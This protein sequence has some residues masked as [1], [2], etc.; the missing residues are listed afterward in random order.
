MSQ[1]SLYEYIRNSQR[2]LNRSVHLTPVRK[3][4][5][6]SLFTSEYLYK[7][8]VSP[9][10]CLP[11]DFD[12]LSGDS[13]FKDDFSTSTHG[14]GQKSNEQKVRDLKPALGKRTLSSP[15]LHGQRTLSSPSLHGQRLLSSPSRHRSPIMSP[16]RK[17][18]KAKVETPKQAPPPSPFSQTKLAKLLMKHGLSIDMSDDSNKNTDKTPTR[19]SDEDMKKSPK[20]NRA[21]PMLS[22]D[23]SRKTLS[24]PIRL[25][26]SQSA[27]H[28]PTTSSSS[29]MTPRTPKTPSKVLHVKS[30]SHMEQ[31]SRKM[32]S[33]RRPNSLSVNTALKRQREQRT[34][35]S[36]DECGTIIPGSYLSPKHISPTQ[37]RKNS[38]NQVAVACLPQAPLSP[39]G[40]EAHDFPRGRVLV[41]RES[42]SSQNSLLD[43]F[44]LPRSS[45]GDC[46][47][48][49]L[50]SDSRKSNHSC[51]ESWIDDRDSK[52]KIMDAKVACT[53]E[54]AFLNYW[55]KETKQEEGKARTEESKPVDE[56]EK[57]WG[58]IDD[59]YES[60]GIKLED[61]HQ[62]AIAGTDDAEQDMIEIESQ[63]PTEC[64]EDRDAEIEDEAET[65]Y[66]SDGEEC[67]TETET[68]NNSEDC[69]I[70]TL[71]SKEQGLQRLEEG[72]QEDKKDGS[73]VQLDV[74]GIEITPRQQMLKKMKDL[75]QSFSNV[76]GRMN[77]AAER[78]KAFEDGDD[79]METDY[80]SDG[81]LTVSSKA[82]RSKAKKSK[83][84][85][86]KSRK[87]SRDKSSKGKSAV[88]RS[89]KNKSSRDKLSKDS[90]PKEKSKS[91][92]A[93]KGQ[94]EKVLLQEVKGFF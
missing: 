73:S 24:A 59:F 11:I 83:L 39:N 3:E 88:D 7:C 75:E 66:G 17:K 82:V 19:K 44:Q 22:P 15:S 87:L 80:S 31:C 67:E 47:L 74:E 54:K 52:Q 40:G 5:K 84:R 55:S 42:N 29:S 37:S 41:R 90:P 30:Q 36:E 78:L 48:A 49:S 72:T 58:E 93:F 85:R 4:E 64:E 45:S 51:E 57:L 60:E 23:R 63:Y 92:K 79:A 61:V 28:T 81:S 38:F 32:G 10:K 1:R 68:A 27:G 8:P 13:R 70:E 62:N 21:K 86:Q 91:K 77:G 53:P 2:S 71:C 20:K 69:P 56:F 65:D 43:K 89:S 33:P 50:F 26:K 9:S 6:K 94:T 46:S 12:E 14:S 18:G 34:R 16:V 35:E 25:L 76:L